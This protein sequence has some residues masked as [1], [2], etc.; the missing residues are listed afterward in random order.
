MYE[1]T[2]AIYEISNWRENIFETCG[3][4]AGRLRT[5]PASGNS[6]AGTPPSISTAAVLSNFHFT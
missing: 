3:K 2:L 1:T 5:P 4:D 6:P